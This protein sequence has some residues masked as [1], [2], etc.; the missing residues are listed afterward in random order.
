MNKPSRKRLHPET[1]LFAV[2]GMTPAV[3]TETVWALAREKPAFVPDRVIAITTTVG[4]RQIAAELFGAGNVWASLQKTLKAGSRLRFGTTA[5]DIRVFACTDPRSGQSRELDDLRTA[6][7]NA[8]AADF[9]LEQ[10]RGLAENPDIRIVSSIAGGRKTMGALLYACMSLIGREGDRL[11]HVLVNEPFERPGLS[12][13]F[14]FPGCG[15]AAVSGVP[16]RIELADIP[17]VPL[18]NRFRDLGEMPGSF[19]GM[20]KRYSEQVKR[21]GAG[22]PRVSLD[23]VSRTVTVA[24]VPVSLR[25]R[26][27]D[28]LRFLMD[29][30]KASRVPSSQKDA[31]E[32]LQ[33]FLGAGGGWVQS[34]DDIK[35]ELSQIRSA[36]TVAGIEWQPG[37]RSRSLLLP[38]WR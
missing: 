5:S 13:K 2:T 8:A 30:N 29:V 25:A 12:P 38:P 16:P 32:P 9:I 14:Y 10:L 31:V 15:P 6:A 23:P 19:G 37:D 35:R 7:D 22:K 17:F 1:V 34:P 33:K 28:V 11:T 36:F 3:L 18:R 4:R 21:D 20:V 26:A 24:G 27:F